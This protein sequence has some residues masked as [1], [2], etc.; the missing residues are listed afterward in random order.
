VNSRIVALWGRL[1]FQPANGG[2]ARSEDLCGAG[3]REWIPA[4]HKGDFTLENARCMT[5][6]VEHR[7]FLPFTAGFSIL[8]GF[9]VQKLIRPAGGKFVFEE[10]F[11][12]SRLPKTNVAS[13]FKP[14]ARRDDFH[15][16][17]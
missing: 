14:C 5:A 7:I 15:V 2:L 10:T 6:A 9:R 1:K 13:G 4:H 16:R 12:K 3:P 11:R 8:L 17:D